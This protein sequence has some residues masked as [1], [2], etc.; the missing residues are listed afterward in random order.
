CSAG[1]VPPPQIIGTSSKPAPTWSALMAQ[2]YHQVS[3][4]LTP[5]LSSFCPGQAMPRLQPRA[6]A[7]P[8]LPLAPPLSG[9]LPAVLLPPVSFPPVSFPPVVVPPV[10]VPV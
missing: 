5:G 2:R 6:G 9:S 8:S 7:P 1:F 3:F 4:E 10:V